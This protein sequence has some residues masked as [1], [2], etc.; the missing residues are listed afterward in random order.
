MRLSRR[1]LARRLCDRAACD[2]LEILPL[3][4]SGTADKCLPSRCGRSME[5][6]VTITSPKATTNSLD[7]I[8]NIARRF[9][10]SHTIGSSCTMLRLYSMIHLQLAS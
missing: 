3:G 5:T 9:V 8:S 7:G 2:S 4:S 10:Y 6:A 1:V